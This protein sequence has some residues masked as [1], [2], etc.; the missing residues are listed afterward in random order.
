MFEI[1]PMPDRVKYQRANDMVRLYNEHILPFIQERVDYNAMYSLRSLWRAG[2]VAIHE[3]DTDHHQ[4]ERAHSNW[5]W[6]ARC[7]HDF[8]ADQLD[9]EGVADYKREVMKLYVEQRD[10]PLL[11]IYR[12]FENHTVLAK[13]LLYDMQWITPIPAVTQIGDR[14]LCEVKVCK[15]L[16]VPGA[17]RVCRVD[18]INVGTS[19]AKS[20]YNIKRTTV[21]SGTGCKITLSP[22]NI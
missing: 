7:S 21:L 20:L 13:A 14:V 6:V 12:M 3:S 16:Q 22:N 15:V 10:R 18:C 5:L 8:L 4:Y 1:R 9:R 11:E 17:T 19:Y 2:I